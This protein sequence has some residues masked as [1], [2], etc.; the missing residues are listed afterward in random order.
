MLTDVAQ[1]IVLN[2]AVAF[3]LGL[4]FGYILGKRSKQTF[5]SAQNSKDINVV[6]KNKFKINPIFNKS[7]S[8]DFKPMVLSSSNKKDNLKKIKGIDENIE[9]ELFK[10][11]IYHFEQI[12]SWTSK[13]TEWVENFLNLPNYARANQWLEQAKI[14]KTGKETNY[15]QKLLEDLENSSQNLEN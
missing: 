1:Y 3:V 12:S 9:N 13:N 4:V 6:E 5:C 7:A 14:L 10:L 15:S 11:G 2:L 8:L